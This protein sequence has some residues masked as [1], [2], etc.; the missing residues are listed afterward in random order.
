MAYSDMSKKGSYNPS[1]SS[2]SK[3]TTNTKSTK[4]TTPST[5]T[6]T[7]STKTTTPSTK[8]IA[9]INKTTTPS[10]KTTTPSTKT[11]TPSNNTVATANKTT[12]TT[13]A[14]TRTSHSSSSTI[15][16]TVA[17][18]NKGANSGNS[19]SNSISN[20]LTDKLVAATTGQT[21][22]AII[23]P[24][25]VASASN[26][27]VVNGGR[28]VGTG[29]FV[30]LNFDKPAAKSPNSVVNGYDKDK[31]QY[32]GAVGDDDKTRTL[33]AINYYNKNGMQDNLKS[34]VEYAD[35]M[36]YFATKAVEEQPKTSSA[37]G[38]EALA[39]VISQMAE[40]KNEIPVQTPVAIT[41][42]VAP[43]KNVITWDD[44]LK[45]ATNAQQPETQQ[46]MQELSDMISSKAE[47]MPYKLASRGILSGGNLEGGYGEIDQTR[48]KQL[49]RIRLQ[50]AQEAIQSAQALRS[51]GLSEYQTDFNNAYQNWYGTNQMALAQDTNARNE[52]WQRYNSVLNLLNTLA[53]NINAVNTQDVA[54]MASLAGLY[55][56]L[57]NSFSPTPSLNNVLSQ[58]L[59]NTLS[60][61]NTKY[62]SAVNSTSGLDNELL[63]FLLSLSE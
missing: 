18:A 46:L 8:T 59:G 13:P 54:K 21:A 42:F 10:T 22:G 17:S 29:G 14:T 27:Q 40:I 37:L 23:G 19:L 57:S 47:M 48:N 53:S 9:T 61:S 55:P 60:D 34:A 31:N 50:Q 51:Q 33:A 28:D 63:S 43:T 12:V 49:D 25:K 3:S 5:K 58:I 41:D 4:T 56:S 20:Y 36:G 39:E 45:Q 2:S 32:V 15:P 62:K 16:S 38:R 11:T 44:A 6:T 1:S 7:P 52:N 26:P 24:T 35:K 30:A